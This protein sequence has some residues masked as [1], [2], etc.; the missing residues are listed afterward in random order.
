MVL[1]Q[2]QEPNYTFRRRK[3]NNEALINKPENSLL[4]YRPL[5]ADFEA[6]TYPG[7]PLLTALVE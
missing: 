4:V 3:P 7:V 6:R 2:T 1:R 5:V